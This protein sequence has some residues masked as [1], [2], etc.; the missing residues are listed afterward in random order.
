MTAPEPNP[1][2]DLDLGEGTA[3]EEHGQAVLGRCDH[4][5]SFRRSPVRRTFTLDELTGPSTDDA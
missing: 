5:L 2:L 4:Q 1:D 3:R